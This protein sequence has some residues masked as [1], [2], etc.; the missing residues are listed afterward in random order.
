MIKNYSKTFKRSVTAVA[1]SAILGI[2]SVAL[3]AN[4]SSSI[5]GSVSV[6]SQNISGYTVVAHNIATGRNR[7]LTTN[8]DGE[9]RFVSLP[10]GTYKITIRNGSTVVAQ[11]TRKVSLGVNSTAIFDL[12]SESDT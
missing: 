1:V 11:E 6:D 12:V 3:A 9:F 8:K 4:N 10:V 7:T 2:S 5:I